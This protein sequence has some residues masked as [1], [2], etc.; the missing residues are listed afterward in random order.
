MSLLSDKVDGGRSPH[1]VF[2]FSTEKMELLR[3][4][5]SLLALLAHLLPVGNEEMRPKTAERLMQ[6]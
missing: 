4:I 1:E 2:S 3:E 5:P 6:A